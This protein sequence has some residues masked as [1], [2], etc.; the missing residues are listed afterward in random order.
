MGGF[1]GIFNQTLTIYGV[2]FS[3]SRVMSTGTP[4]NALNLIILFSG[5]YSPLTE[6]KNGTT[7]WLFG[8]VLENLVPNIGSLNINTFPTGLSSNVLEGSGSSGMVID[9]SSASAQASSIYF[10]AQG[11]NNAVKLTQAMLQ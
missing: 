6:F 1:T 10:G 3:A 9:N 4:T 2:P 5:E 11:T 7:D 8:G